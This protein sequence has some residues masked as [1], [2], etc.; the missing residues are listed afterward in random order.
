MLFRLLSPDGRCYSFDSRASG[1]GRGEGCATIVIKPLQDAIRDGDPIRAIIRETAAN[2]D[3]RTPTITSPSQAAQEELVRS[4]Y[5]NAGLDPGD[6]GY[7]EAHGTGTIVGDS[8]EARALGAVLG[9]KRPKQSEPLL[10]G[11]VKTNIGHTEA[12]SGL[13]GVIKAVLCLEKGQIPPS[14]NLD[15]LNA[16][17]P[18]DDLNIRIPRSLEPWPSS[19]LRRVSVNNFG[20]GGANAHV[21]IEDPVYLTR[22]REKTSAD[23]HRT[24]RAGRSRI[25]KLSAK[26][27]TAARTVASNLRD[28]LPGA[29]TGQDP[30]DLLDRLAHTLG[31]RRSHFHWNVAVAASSVEQLIRILGSGNTGPS[32]SSRQPRLG[33]VFTGQGA[34]WYAMGRELIDLY[35]V[36]RSSLE[37]ADQCLRE[38]GF[39]DSLIGSFHRTGLEGLTDM[40]TS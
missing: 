17:I 19:S 6:T 18:F 16:T 23:A 34:Q 22:G 36:F 25:F 24:D 12:A 7:A 26:D 8:T 2:Q 28:Y 38:L 30:S 4:C 29:G 21:I 27:A 13:A 31:R 20:Y 14:V 3:G 32:K 1:Y 37:R 15:R 11:S 9:M 33:F 39:T 5:R 35:P 10:L 40:L